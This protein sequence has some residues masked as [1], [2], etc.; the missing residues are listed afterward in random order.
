MLR[1]E[2][3][4]LEYIEHESTYNRFE[5]EILE[6][7]L[8]LAERRGLASMWELAGMNEIAFIEDLK[9]VMLVNAVRSVLEHHDH[10]V[11]KKEGK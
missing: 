7:N 11:R 1:E 10:D 4:M 3:A 6:A 9:Y 5:R 2:D 8:L